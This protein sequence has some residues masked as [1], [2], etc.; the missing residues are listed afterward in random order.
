MDAEDEPTDPFAM[1]F[2]ERH[3][4][5]RA[6]SLRARTVADLAA[7]GRVTPLPSQGDVSWERSFLPHVVLLQR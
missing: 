3:S 7:R 4:L 5:G 1:S 2:L 6:P